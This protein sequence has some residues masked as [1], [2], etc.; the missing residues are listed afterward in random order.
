MKKI[1]YMTDLYYPAKGRNYYEE[2]LYITQRLKDSFDLVLCHPQNS[3]SFEDDV[4]LVIF[5]NT[6]PVTGFSDVYDDF[7][8]RVKSKGL[9]TFNEFTGKADM[10]GKQ[11]LLDLTLE[12]FPVIPT[13]DTIDDLGLLPDCERYVIKPKDGAD[14]IGLEFLTKDEIFERDLSNT[15]IQPAIDF[16]YE[17]SFYF[18]NDKLEYALYA[19]DKS[20]R[21][22]L[23]RYDFTES[24]IEFAEKFIKWNGI[25]YGIQRVDACRTREGELLLVE[26]EDLN[27]YLSIL[28]LDDVTRD[29]FIDDLTVALNELLE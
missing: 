2:D 25:R 9:K 12:K 6:G 24:D 3:E 17:V 11:Y 20:K 5:R 7:V 23:H 8:N 10:C 21:W 1:L 28:E 16:E 19:P 27:P 14:S 4:D 15:L 18:I 22:D 29:N 13:V 26:L